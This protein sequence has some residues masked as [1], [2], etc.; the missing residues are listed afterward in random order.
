M[1]ARGSHSNR[2]EGRERRDLLVFFL[3]LL[4][5]FGCLLV[6]AQMAIGPASRWRVAADM[7]S[8]LDL[9][10]GR[11]IGEVYVEPLLPEVMTP[12]AWDPRHVLTPI[13]TVIVVPL[14]TLAPIPTSTPTPQ[15][16]ALVPTPTPMPSPTS[17]PRTP[18]SAPAPTSTPVPTPTPVPTFTP[19]PTPVPTFTPTPTSVPT[20]TPTP[21]PTPIPSTFTPTAIPTT[22]TETTT[23]TPTPTDTPT[24]TETPTPT[25]VPP[26]SVFSITPDRGVNSAPVPVV[27]RGANFFGMPTARLRSD[28]PITISAATTDTLTGTLPTGL[29]PGVYALTVV[30][31]DAQSGMLSPAYIALNPPSPDTTLETGYVL[32]FGPALTSPGN[33]DNDQVQVIFLEIPDAVTDTLYVRIFDPD[34]GG[35]LSGAFDEQHGGWD[36]AVTFSLYGGSGAYT[37]PAARQATF[38]TTADPGIST[39]AMIVS[40]TFAV[41]DTLNGD[42]YLFATLDPDWGEAVGN[43]RVFKLSVVGAGSGDDGNLYN[44]ALSTDPLANIAPVGSR[45]FAYSWTFPLAL[46]TSQRPP[47]YPYVP[48]GTALFEQHNWDMDYADGTMTLHTPTDDIFVSGSGISGDNAEA[49]SSH[50]VGAEEDGATWTVTMEFSPLGA[51]SWN[52]VTFWT[53]GDGTALA[54]FT[55]PTIDPPP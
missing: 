26:P 12:P 43:K 22:P 27:I 9:D 15:E 53:V 20:F 31:P 28:A 50:G 6:T 40:Q 24:P 35:P 2:D 21:A 42:W 16:V 25:P 14:V 36:T 32:T 7:L 11:D 34:V 23:P 47:L 37:D 33:G 17:L 38:A 8:E 39:G 19:T 3:I 46:D 41:S 55:R 51:A 54:I 45:V 44:V 29:I 4:L 52:D 48:P 1:G 18:T 49:W 13:G 5:G 10:E 30:N